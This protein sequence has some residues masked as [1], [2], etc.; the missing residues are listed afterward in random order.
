MSYHPTEGILSDLWG[1][2][3]G[4][5]ECD[6]AELGEEFC[7]LYKKKGEDLAAAKAEGLTVTPSSGNNDLIKWGAAAVVVAFLV[8]RKKQS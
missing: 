4:R 5:S 7:A 6:P 1:K 2:F 8:F 3:T